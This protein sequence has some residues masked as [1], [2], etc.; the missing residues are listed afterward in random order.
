MMA[1][2]PIPTGDGPFGFGSNRS[3]SAMMR[4]VCRATAHLLSGTENLAPAEFDEPPLACRCPADGRC[5]AYATRRYCRGTTTASV[6]SRRSSRRYPECDHGH[7]EPFSLEVGS[8]I[9]RVQSTEI[10][11]WRQEPIS[12]NWNSVER[13]NRNRGQIAAPPYG[14]RGPGSSDF[15]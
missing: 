7:A 4:K 13:G 12:V 14:A 8:G 10:F 2:A 3:P 6:F 5:S 15:S 11:Q 9:E 1:I